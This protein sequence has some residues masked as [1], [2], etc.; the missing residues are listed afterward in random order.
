MWWRQVTLNPLLISWNL[1]NCPACQNNRKVTSEMIL[2]VRHFISNLSDNKYERLEYNNL[3]YIFFSS[4]IRKCL[5]HWHLKLDLQLCLLSQNRCL[6]KKYI[7][8]TEKELTFYM[9]W[10][11]FQL[12]DI[13]WTL[14]DKYNQYFFYANDS[15]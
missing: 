7:E 4:V 15:Y 12:K 10:G 3:G 9:C 14:L 8:I 2:E 11:N 13:L 5:L 1:G 6:P